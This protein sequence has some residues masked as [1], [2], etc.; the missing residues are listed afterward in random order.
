MKKGFHEPGDKPRRF[1]KDVSV[2]AEAGG[3]QVKLDG[4]NVRSPKG[5]VLV[6]P[7]RALADLA[8][9]EWAG[10]VDV[11]ELAGMNVT[12]LAFTALEAVPQAR[13]GVAQQVAD[14]A[15]S[16][17]LCYYAEEPQAL[18]A[19]QTHHWSPLLDRAERELG[20][21]FLRAAGIVHRAQPD[22][23]LA[24]VKALVLELDD[25]ALAGVAFGTSLFGS[26]VLALTLQR[27]W[28][29][30]EQAYEL[31]RLDEAYQQEKWGIDEEAAERTARLFEESTMLDRWFRA[32][33]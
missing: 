30:G 20:L 17:L 24:R 2:V 9:A 6:L 25:F 15:G 14:F 5:G 11:I 33:G 23:T 7:T 10:Q 27:G 4:R 12:R 3:F 16:D 21:V 31:S 29:T 22:E 32:L 28:L 8:A 1:Y 13:D 19:R 18:A 26:A